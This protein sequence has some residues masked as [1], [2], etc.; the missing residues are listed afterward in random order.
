M[1]LR[2]ASNIGIALFKQI[3]RKRQLSFSSEK[4]DRHE[5]ITR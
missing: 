2:K 3:K 4:I 5:E 1:V